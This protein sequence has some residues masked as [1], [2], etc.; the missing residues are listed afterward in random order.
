MAQ[1]VDLLFSLNLTIGPKVSARIVKTNS[2]TPTIELNELNGV[3]VTF[4]DYRAEIKSIHRH[5]RFITLFAFKVPGSIHHQIKGVIGHAVSLNSNSTQFE[6][7]FPKTDSKIK[8]L[9]LG[10][11]KQVKIVL[12]GYDEIGRKLSVTVQSSP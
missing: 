7:P 1:K 2:D 9:I 8:Q 11:Q 10:T 3:G 12:T 4:T 6:L 5:A